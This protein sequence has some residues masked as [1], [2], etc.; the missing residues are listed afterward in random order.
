MRA[1]LMLVVLALLAA[2]GGRSVPESDGG[3]GDAAPQQDQGPKPDGQPFVQDGGC[4]RPPGGCFSPQDCP[5]G[6]DCMG[7]FPDP[8][9]PMCAVCYGKCVPKSDC[10]SNADCTPAEFCKFD[11]VA[12]DCGKTVP[13]TCSPVPSMCPES[14]APVCGCDGKTYTN[15]CFAAAQ[16]VSVAATGACNEQ[17]CVKLDQAYQ[18]AVDQGKSC[19][20]MCN[21]IPCTV[22]VQTNLTCPCDTFI[23]TGSAA[24]QQLTSLASQWKALGCDSIGWMCPGVACPNV[25]SATCV[26]TSSGTSGKCQ[27]VSSP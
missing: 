7:C 10:W 12:G 1:G 4:V 21:Y 5:A 26:P 3:L 16:S 18:A 22:K 9:C 20:P 25:T 19:C 14:Y 17:Q 11:P 15:D 24:I 23:D 27:D 6:N 8:C 13:G 2:C